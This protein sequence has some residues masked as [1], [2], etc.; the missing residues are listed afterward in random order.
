MNIIGNYRFGEMILNGKPYSRDLI[1][2]PNAIIENWW[3]KE[4]HRCSLTD[5]EKV[6]SSE[7]E[8]LIIGSGKFGLLK[9]DA[10]AVNYFNGQ[11][12]EVIILKT[13][14]AV[15][16]YNEMPGKKRL[17]AAFHLTC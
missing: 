10:E 9:V 16:K 17:A 1:I 7:I 11:Q 4:G 8:C 15:R 5:L 6:P 3:R 12:V 13:A 2:T 14:D